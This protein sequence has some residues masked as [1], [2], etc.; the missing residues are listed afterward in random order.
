MQTAISWTDND[1]AFISTDDAGL[2]ATI[3]EMQERKPDECVIIMEPV[4]NEGVMCA[5]CPPRWVRLLPPASGTVLETAD[6][7]RQALPLLKHNIKQSKK[8]RL[9]LLWQED[10][11]N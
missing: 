11:S 2:I 6:K 9:S 7:Y 10:K 3:R 4:D 8:G 5:K 1:W